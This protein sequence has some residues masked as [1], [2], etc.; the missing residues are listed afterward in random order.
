M[1]APTRPPADVFNIKTETDSARAYRGLVN[2][3]R[4]NEREREGLT[5]R[6]REL[7]KQHAMNAAMI[8]AYENAKS[9][10]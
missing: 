5:L 4:R 10:T 7:E 6:I 8:E 2:A 9:G 3:Q 1:N